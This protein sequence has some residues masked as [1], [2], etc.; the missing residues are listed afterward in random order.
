MTAKAGLRKHS[1]LADTA[2]LQEFTQQCNL[3]VWEILDPLQ[4]KHKEKMGALCALS[5]LK[6]KQNRDLKGHTVADRSKQKNMYPKSETASPMLSTAA[7]ILTILINAYERHGLATADVAGAYLKA[8][9]KDYVIIKFVGKS[10][11]ILLAIKPTY[12]KFVSMEKGV[13]V[14]YAWL[15]KALYRCV[16]SALL[17]YTLFHDTLKQIGFVINHYNPCVANC[18]IEGSQCTI[19]WYIDDTKIS[20]INPDVVT[21]IIDTLKKHFG[22]MTVTRG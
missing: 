20:H 18:M 17:W 19:T 12:N 15:K 11:D 8:I 13:K 7:L 10:V 3:D 2:L 5:L 16:Q 14:L 9:M 22:K 6:E 4:L 21:K 1:V